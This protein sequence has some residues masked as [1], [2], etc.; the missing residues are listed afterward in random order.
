[1][2][3]FAFLGAYLGLWISEDSQY[4]RDI[5]SPKNALNLFIRLLPCWPLIFVSELHWHGYSLPSKLLGKYFLPPFLADL[6]LYGY[7]HYF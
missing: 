4:S 3:T 7:S 2:Y 1:M 5:V 6:Y